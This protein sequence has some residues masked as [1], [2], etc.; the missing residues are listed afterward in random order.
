MSGHPASLPSSKGGRSTVLLSVFGLAV[1]ELWFA[2][3]AGLA[4][5][6]DP[7]LIWLATICGGIFGVGI[8]AVGGDRIRTWFL[9]RRGRGIISGEGRLYRLWLRYGV[10]GWGLLSPLVVAAAMG[11]AIGIALGAPRRLLFLSMSAGVVLWTTIVVGAAVL[12]IHAFEQ[13]R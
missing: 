11:T 4:L 10:V 8:V 2:V 13:L 9:R 3:P 1:F 12:G 7:V 5:G 6:L